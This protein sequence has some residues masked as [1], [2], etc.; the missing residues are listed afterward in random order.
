MATFSAR[1]FAAVDTLIGLRDV[2]GTDRSLAHVSRDLR[3]ERHP[4][5]Y[6]YRNIPALAPAEAD[7]V[8]DTLAAMDANGVA[9]GMLS[10]THP[11]SAGAAAAHPDRFVLATQVDPTDPMAAAR[12]VRRDHA[13][14]DIRAVTLFPPGGHPAVAVDDPRTYVVY[15]ACV[16]LDLPV[17]VTA[18]VPG[19]RVPFDSQHVEHFDQVCYDFPELDVVLRHGAEP[20]DELAVKLMIKWPNLHYSTSA[21]APRYYPSSII[22]FANTRGHHQVL[23]GGYYPYALE[24]DRIFDELAEVPFRDHVWPKF[25]RQNAARLLHIT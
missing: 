24:L 8:A 6:M 11:S 19:P 5:D 13:V 1:R 17:F 9:V 16:E 3:G 4:A 22:E 18:G 20:W 15:A 25:L 21:F 14:H 10:L 2:E 12:Q 23:Y 7:V